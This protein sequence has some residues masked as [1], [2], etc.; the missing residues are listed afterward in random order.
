MVFATQQVQSQLRARMEAEIPDD[1]PSAF[2]ADIQPDQWEPMQKLLGE[3]GATDLESVPVVVARVREVDGK[4]VAEMVDEV[5]GGGGRRWALTREQRLTYMEKLPEGN[6][7]VAGELWI[8]PA[9]HELSVDQEFANDLGVHLGSIVDFDVQGVPMSFVVTSLRAVDWESFGL[10]FFIVVEPGALEGAPQVRIATAKLPRGDEQTIQ[11]QVVA[12][13]PNVTVV[14]VRDVLDRI[15]KLLRRLSWGISFLGAFTLVAGLV[16]LAATV[17]V[18]SSRRGR[19]VALLK[20]LRHAPRRSRRAVRHRV[21]AARL[22]RGHDRRARAAAWWRWIAIT[23]AMEL[24]V[25]ERLRRVRRRDRGRGRAVG[26]GRGAARASARLRR[27]PA[28]GP[29]VGVA[30]SLRAHRSDDHCAE[31]R[32][33][34]LLVDAAASLTLHEAIAL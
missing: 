22:D 25:E 23:R 4:P 16:I 13:F 28:R 17:G 21:R 32:P 24:A 9:R 11:D 27:R 7:I 5:G 12:A 3:R 30:R 2:F 26:G 18:E 1:A 14:M 8:D 34:P 10:N 20:T 33:A 29:A 15:V 6:R 31:A 19:E